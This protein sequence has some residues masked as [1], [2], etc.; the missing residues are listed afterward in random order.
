MKGTLLIKFHRDFQEIGFKSVFVG[1]KSYCNLLE[2][3][4]Y[5]YRMKGI[6]QDIIKKKNRI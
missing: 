5:H 1:K 3:G 4:T 2:D 6:L